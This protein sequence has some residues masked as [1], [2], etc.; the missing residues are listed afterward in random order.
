MRAFLIVSLLAM[1]SAFTARF[2]AR[3]FFLLKLL[4]VRQ[5]L[6]NTTITMYTTITI[7]NYCLT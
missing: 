4:F 6:I 7:Y 2:G 1:A 3:K 5:L